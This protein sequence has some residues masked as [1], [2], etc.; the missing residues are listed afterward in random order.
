MRKLGITWERSHI[1]MCLFFID[2]CTVYGCEH[3]D[4]LVKTVSNPCLFVGKEVHCRKTVI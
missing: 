4:Q 3:I 2:L 1:F